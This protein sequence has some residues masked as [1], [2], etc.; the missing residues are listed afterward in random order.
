LAEWFKARS[1]SQAD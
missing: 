1:G